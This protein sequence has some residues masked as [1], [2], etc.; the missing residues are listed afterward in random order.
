MTRAP[1]KRDAWE[2]DDGFPTYSLE[3]LDKMDRAFVNA[4]LAIA[5]GTESCPVGVDST[6]GTKRPIIWGPR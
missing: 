2:P 3:Q 1:S 5:A 4:M 6:P